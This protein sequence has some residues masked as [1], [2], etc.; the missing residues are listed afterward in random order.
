M[1]DNRHLRIVVAPVAERAGEYVARYCEEFLQADFCVYL[2]DSIRGAL[3][4]HSFA[5]MIRKSFGKNYRTGEIEFVVCA[6]E[7]P[8]GSQALVEVVEHRSAFCA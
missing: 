8:F 5:E 4:L 7:V 2:K 3:A 1:A 6:Q